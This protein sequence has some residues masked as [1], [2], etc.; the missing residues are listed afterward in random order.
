[1]AIEELKYFE[2]Q[3][4][5][6]TSHVNTIAM[7]TL[8]RRGYRVRTERALPIVRLRGQLT[9]LE[10]WSHSLAGIDLKQNQLDVLTD[11]VQNLKEKSLGWSK[12]I[13]PR[14]LTE[15]RSMTGAQYF[16]L[17]CLSC[18]VLVREEVLGVIKRNKQIK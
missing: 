9:G 15:R 2:H 5:M 18:V 17:F 4:E 6:I 16:V 11:W 1:M 13:L 12:I 7:A 14:H 8:L 3:G 10:C